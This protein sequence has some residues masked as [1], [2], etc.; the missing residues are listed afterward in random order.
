MRTPH[1]HIPRVARL[2][3]DAPRFNLPHLELGRRA[4]KSLDRADILAL[5]LAVTLAAAVTVALW[6]PV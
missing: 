6:L 1:L 4:P 5:V 3:F 2:H